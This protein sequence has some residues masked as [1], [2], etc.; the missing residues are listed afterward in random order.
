MLIHFISPCCSGN[1]ASVDPGR[2]F[3]VVESRGILRAIRGPAVHGTASEVTQSQRMICADA[4]CGGPNT[5]IKPT[6]DS[7]CSHLVLQR[8]SCENLNFLNLRRSC[9]Q[10]VGPRSEG[11][12]NLATQVGIAA[13]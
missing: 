9:E 12:R 8:C 10:F 6:C 2:S 5:A 1:Q 3:D 11:F 7:N 13:T 4:V